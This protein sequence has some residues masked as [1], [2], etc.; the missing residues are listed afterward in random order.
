MTH[1]R[2][3]FTLKWQSRGSY[4]HG[5]TTS[6]NRSTSRPL[7]RIDANTLPDSASCTVPSTFE[8]DGTSV[9]PCEL[10]NGS[11]SVAVKLS[12][13]CALFDESVS[14]SATWNRVFSGIVAEEG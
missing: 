13:E 10:C 11:S 12:P 9:S 7:P 4:E 5:S 1:L 14:S 8:P 2:V 6:S 3:T